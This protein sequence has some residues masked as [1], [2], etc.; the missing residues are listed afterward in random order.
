MAPSALV[1]SQLI[2]YLASLRASGIAVEY[3]VG[4]SFVERSARAAGGEK[5]T[6]TTLD[7]IPSRV[8]GNRKGA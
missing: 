1:L 2:T 4:I 8:R 3:L 5:S 6:W 7:T